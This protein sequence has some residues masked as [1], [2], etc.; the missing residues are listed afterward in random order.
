VF[1]IDMF[2]L[3]PLY[4]LR[5]CIEAYL[6]KVLVLSHTKKGLS[7]GLQRATLDKKKR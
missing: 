5:V 6:F 7:N 4:F 3:C 2:V 1:A